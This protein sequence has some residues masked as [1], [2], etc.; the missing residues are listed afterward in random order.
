MTDISHQS[1][2]AIGSA[3]SWYLRSMD[4]RAAYQIPTARLSPAARQ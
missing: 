2:T 3:V 1:N 4:N